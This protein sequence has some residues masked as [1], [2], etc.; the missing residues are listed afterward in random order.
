[1]KKLSP[2]KIDTELLKRLH[3]KPA[4]KQAKSWTYT[5]GDPREFK[6]N[7][8]LQMLT[9]QSSRCAYCGRKLTERKPHRDH[10]APRE[11]HPEFTFIPLN[12]VLA[13]FCCNT[14]CKGASD[15]V[16]AKSADYSKCSFSIIHPFLDDPAD[17]I[18]FTGGE[19]AILV[20]VVAGSSKGTATVTMFRLDSP[21]LTKERAKN[22]LLDHDLD[23]LPGKWRDGFVFANANAL[24]MKLG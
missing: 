3:A 10:I 7:L 22:V 17:H 24:K 20:Q 4:D 14:E 13:C 2:A 11:S 23:H 8:T 5:N 6:D 16:S 18:Q 21:E 1:M 19:D 12:L 9:N 15:T